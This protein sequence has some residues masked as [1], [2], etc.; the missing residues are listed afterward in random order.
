M[1][2]KGKESNEE[3]LPDALSVKGIKQCVTT[4]YKLTVNLQ[5]HK[6]KRELRYY[7]SIATRCGKNETR[8]GTWA[9]SVECDHYRLVGYDA[10]FIVH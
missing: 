9:V 2:D 3:I 7:P 8:S 5:V 4:R 1:N 6:S 10:V